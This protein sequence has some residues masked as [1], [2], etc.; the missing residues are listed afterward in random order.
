MTP[1]LHDALAAGVTVITPNRR[2]A[3]HLHREFD[4]RQHAAGRRAWPT[5]VLLPYSIWLETLWERYVDAGAADA[6]ARLL[7]LAQSACLWQRVVADSSALL[8]DA[9]GASR[10]AADAWALLHGWGGGGESWRAWRRDGVE[11]DDAATFAAWAESYQRLLRNADA[12]DSAQLPDLLAANA[13]RIASESSQL[14]FVGFLEFSPQQERLIAALVNAG[15]DVRRLEPIAMRPAAAIRTTAPTPSDEWL[16][17]LAWARELARA[18]P[19]VRIGIVIEDLAQHREQ[20]IA[21]ADDVLCPERLLAG[22]HAARKPFEVSLGSALADVPLVRCA[23][24]LLTIASTGLATQDAAALLRSPY[25]A[26]AESGWVQRARVERDWIEAGRRDAT[27][28]DAIAALRHRDVTLAARW[29]AAGA[30]LR[31]GA[32][33]TPRQW[34]DQ[35]RSWLVA[36]GWLEDIALDSAEYQAR[37]AF[38]MLLAEFARLGVV[39]PTLE[40]DAAVGLLRALVQ[41]RVFQPEGGDATIQLLGVLEGSGLSFDA[42]RG[43]TVHQPGPLLLG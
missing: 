35:W 12:I 10:I 9:V 34:T 4:R 5:A 37:G 8:L 17:A 28:A 32:T 2:L 23:L 29:H 13:P 36:A 1:A 26:G 19:H 21:L 18:Q 27:L 3:R 16:A 22:A 41:E 20:I 43:R 42:I 40:R 14:V 33:A 25:V 30:A 7:S 24:D 11:V 6:P 38:D 39:S 31:T 15:G